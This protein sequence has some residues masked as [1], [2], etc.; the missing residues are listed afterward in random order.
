MQ[1]IPNSEIVQF[2]YGAYPCPACS[3]AGPIVVKRR[4]LSSI[5]WAECERCNQ[6]GPVAYN[7]ADAV[8]YWNDQA[9]KR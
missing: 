9:T 4:A 8:R 3:S 6:R 2:A 5:R 1:D 7:Q